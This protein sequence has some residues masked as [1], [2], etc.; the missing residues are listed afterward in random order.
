MST[1]SVFA[2]SVHGYSGLSPRF[3]CSSSG[4][5]MLPTASTR[6]KPVRRDSSNALPAS[7]TAIPGAPF[8][9]SIRGELK[10]SA[11]VSSTVSSGSM[12]AMRGAASSS[13]ANTPLQ[14]SRTSNAGTSLPTISFWTYAGG[15]H[16]SGPWK[17]TVACSTM[18][19]SAGSASARDNASRAACT[20]IS[21]GE[22]SSATQ[23][24]VMR[25]SR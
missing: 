7:P 14:P 4:I 2:P 11:V 13:P 16:I 24:P 18:P 23:R 6:A 9:R 12:E 3:S 5:A 21:T 15:C 8:Q 10:F 19:M 22:T 25:F 20:A 17:N 1:F